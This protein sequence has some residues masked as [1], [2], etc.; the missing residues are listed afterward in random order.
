MANQELYKIAQRRIDRRN[1]RWALWGIDLA[2]LIFFV[3]AIVVFSDTA[4]VTLVSA[5]MLA[6][7]GIFVLHTIITVMAHSRDEDIEKEVAKLRE[8]AML[9]EKPKR[10]RL[11]EDGE[12][13]DDTDADWYHEEAE[14][15]LRSE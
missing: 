11:T 4:Y 3:A 2:I 5:G 12:I 10:M 6:W 15:R 14:R 1:F 8:A 7:G 13:T 9:Y